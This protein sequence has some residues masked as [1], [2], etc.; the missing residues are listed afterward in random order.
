M[1]ETI[2]PQYKL[3]L[4]YDILPEAAEEY[5]RFTMGEFVP[6][7]QS[8]GLYMLR[9]WHTAYGDYPIRQSE[10]VAEDLATVREALSSPQFREMEEHLLEFVTNYHRKLVKFSDKFQF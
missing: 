8:M 5:Y 10:F 4:T 1:A 9:A 7:L 3:M 2:V 6:A